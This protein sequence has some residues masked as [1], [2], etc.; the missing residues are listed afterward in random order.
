MIYIKFTN[1]DNVIKKFSNAP[2]VLLNEMEKAMGRSLSMVETESKRR[3]PVATGLLRSS[4]GGAQ[5]Y[6]F[7]KPFKAGVG[8][9]VRYAIY[10]HEGHGRH[11][12]GERKFM[13]KGAKTSVPFIQKTLDE[14]LK[15]LAN[16]LTQ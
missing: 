14:A 3:T 15:N 10:V 9:N 2:V 13:E 6:K 11:K 1:I 12:V 7:V 16:Y 8:T 5:G 4:I